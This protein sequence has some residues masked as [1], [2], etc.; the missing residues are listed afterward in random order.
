MQRLLVLLLL[1]GL[2]KCAKGQ[3][4]DDVKNVM[5]TVTSSMNVNYNVCTDNAGFPNYL[6]KQVNT[7]LEKDTL[8][9]LSPEEKIELQDKLLAAQHVPK[10]QG[11]AVNGIPIIK[12]DTVKKAMGDS[13]KVWE[14][15]KKKYPKPFSYTL[16]TFS[17]PVF[18]RNNT[19]CLFY[20]DSGR[21]GGLNPWNHEEDASSGEL[22]IYIKDGNT[23]VKKI[24]VYCYNT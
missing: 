8:L 15:F 7:Y 5:R 1:I 20:S 16:H 11:S 9:H 19:V 18:I 14:Y 2:C 13:A 22:C 4:T 21:Y 6:I 10:W 17:R 12:T 23:W 3:E 24:T